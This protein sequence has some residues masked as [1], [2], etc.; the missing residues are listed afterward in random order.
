MKDKLDIVIITQDDSLEDLMRRS[1]KRVAIL[2]T[3]VLEQIRDGTAELKNYEVSYFSF[4]T[5]EKV[6]EF[7][8]R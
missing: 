8:K 2:V 4:P 1:K 3:K 5:G 7:K 6:M